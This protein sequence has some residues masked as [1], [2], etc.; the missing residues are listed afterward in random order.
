MKRNVFETLVGAFVL[1]VAAG[2]AYYAYALTGIGSGGRGGYE[3]VVQFQKVDGLAVGGDV[4]ISGIKVG[5]IS[6]LGLDPKTYQAEVR[7]R[8]PDA[9]KIPVDTIAQIASDGLLGGK[10][11]SL[12]PGNSDDVLA[13]GGRVRFSNPPVDLLDLLG[14]FIFTMADDKAKAGGAAPK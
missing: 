9:I 7:V 8:I 11:L 3:I 14:R 12:L 5:T 1:V 13:P 4:R 10:Y 6:S 2:F